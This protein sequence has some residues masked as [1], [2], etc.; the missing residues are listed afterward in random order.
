MDKIDKMLKAIS[1]SAA[2]AL[3]YGTLANAQEVSHPTNSQPTAI[4]ASTAIDPN[5]LKLDKPA[6]SQSLVYSDEASSLI[7]PK[8]GFQGL[9]LNS[10]YSHSIDTPYSDVLQ[11]STSQQYLVSQAETQEPEPSEPSELLEESPEPSNLPEATEESLNLKPNANPLL[12]PTVPEEVEIDIT[13]P[14]TLEQ[15]IQIAIANNQDLKEARL[16][17]QR[18]Q[19]ELE[20]ARADLYPE[21]AVQADITQ[22]DSASGQASFEDAETDQRLPIDP[23][24]GGTDV[25]ITTTSTIF[26][27]SLSLTYD[28]YSGGA[29]R[30]DIKRAKRQIDFNALDLERI[31]AQTRFEAARDYYALQD[32]A[33]QVEI[34]EA[35]VADA[36]QTLRNAQLL[37]QAGLGTRFDV[38]QAEV[39]LANAQQSLTSAIANQNI[40]SRQLAE[41]L[42]VGS[43]VGLEAADE[44]EEAGIW[45]LSLEETIVLAYKYRAELEQ[46]LVQREIN[47]QQRRIALANIKPQVSLFASYDYYD[48]LKDDA[49]ITDGYSVGG[50]IQWLLFD[51]GE[52]KAIARQERTDIEIAE[53]AF[54]NQRDAIR[55]EVEQAYYNLAANEENIETSQRAVDLAEESLR[56]ARLRFQ[57]GVGTQ[58]EVI[59]AQTALTEARGNLLSAIIDYNQ[60]LNQLQRAVTNFPDGRLFDLP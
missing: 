12:F 8:Q 1:T 43:Q 49:D 38:L 26:N 57:A 36:Q 23:I 18:S 53:N 25:N 58:T 48:D 55:L 3:S 39:E 56:L 14:I 37:E 51:G 50:R 34:Q 2:I 15:A 10:S 22:A 24:T 7:L 6:K 9:E 45:Q 59:D 28:I 46:F 20:Q 17:L 27:S 41:T 19:F 16:N 54:S 42:N 60:S 44:I 21:L 35:A 31:A 52:A 47:E 40:A 5:T 4:D 30:A 29:V 13:E 33:A 32:A 11:Q